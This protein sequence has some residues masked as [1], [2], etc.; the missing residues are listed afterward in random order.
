M[1]QAEMSKI[2][3]NILG[4]SISREMASIVLSPKLMIPTHRGPFLLAKMGRTGREKQSW[5]TCDIKKRRAGCN[6]KKG[7]VLI[8]IYPGPCLA[9]IGPTFYTGKN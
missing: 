6:G 9:K 7:N 8:M 1:Y 5:W 3:L 2:S 4:K